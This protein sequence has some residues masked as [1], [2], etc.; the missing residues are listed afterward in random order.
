M[1]SC[2]QNFPTNLQLCH[3]IIVNTTSNLPWFLLAVHDCCLWILWDSLLQR[4][5]N[6]CLINNL[7][8]IIPK[9]SSALPGYKNTPACISSAFMLH[10]FI[11]TTSVSCTPEK[12]MNAF[13]KSALKKFHHNCLFSQWQ[14]LCFAVAVLQPISQII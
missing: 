13:L 2:G 6:G 10:W 14:C 1:C 8:F 3:G 7:T 12:R 4:G 9:S 5:Y 11:F